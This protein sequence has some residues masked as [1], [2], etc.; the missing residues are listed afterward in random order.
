MSMILFA[1]VV[2]V[3]DGLPLSASTDFHPNKD[4]IECRKR[5]KILSS[6]LARCP[7]R[8]TAKG[9]VLSIQS[10]SKLSQ[11]ISLT[12]QGFKTKL[13]KFLLNWNVRSF[14]TCG[15]VAFMSICSSSFPAAMAFCFLEA[16]HWEF[17]ASYD[18][19]RVGLASRPYAFL[20]FDGT[21]QKAKEYFNDVSCSQLK[22]DVQQEPLDPAPV[23]LHLEDVAEANGVANGHTAAHLES[24]PSYRMQPVSAL[25][26][27]SLILNIMCAA[28]NL[29][30]G[31]HLAEHSFQ[32]DHEGAGNVIAFLIAFVACILQCY[33][34]L[35]YTSARKLRSF[36][37]WIFICLCNVYLHGP[38]N[39]WQIVFHIGVASLSACQTVTRRLWEKQLDCGL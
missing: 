22:E 3:R 12:L 5:L 33:L 25:G 2:R 38:R 7:D 13:D 16:L 8:G 27:L 31:V 11:Q 39:L 30:R 37:L 6:T 23:I 36:G 24:A 15:D 19:I 28:L 34:Y 26:I 14:H 4:F 1:C 29:I 9:R 20:D 21:I 10:L 18:S 35:F 17:R 32:E